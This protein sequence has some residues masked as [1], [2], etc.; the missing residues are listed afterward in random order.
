MMT[1]W[2]Q[3]FTGHRCWVSGWGKDQFGVA[4][5]YQ[6]VL[7]EVDVSVL[8]HDTCQARLQVGRR[9][10]DISFLFGKWR[11]TQHGNHGLSREAK[12]EDGSCV[13]LGLLVFQ[14]IFKAVK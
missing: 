5:S 7:K 9:C 8:D 6:N 12:C 13:L 4:G 1:C 14:L 3:D 11:K 10:I 2:L